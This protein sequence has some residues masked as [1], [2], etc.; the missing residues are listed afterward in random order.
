M[1]C[2]CIVAQSYTGFSMV[3][4]QIFWAYSVYSFILKNLQFSIY[5]L[6]AVS[7][8]NDVTLRRG[9]APNESLGLIHTSA[10]GAHSGRG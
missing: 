10:G 2:Y 4:I 5:I 1:P 9:L 6:F 8:S 3:Q 7:S